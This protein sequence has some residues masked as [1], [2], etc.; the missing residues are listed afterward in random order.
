MCSCVF[1]NGCVVFLFAVMCVVVI[2]AVAAVFRCWLWWIVVVV[3]IVADDLD[4]DMF[5]EIE[6]VFVVNPW[7]SPPP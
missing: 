7:W 3:H 2:D 4:A 6:V 5:A 1:C